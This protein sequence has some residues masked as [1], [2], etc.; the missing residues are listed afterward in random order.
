MPTTR[1][2]FVP[3]FVFF[4][5]W[6]SHRPPAEYLTWAVDSF[7]LSTAIARPETSIH[8]HM[9]YCDFGDCMEAIDRLDADVNS[10]E[11]GEAFF[12]A[13]FLFFLLVLLIGPSTDRSDG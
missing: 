8:T 7:L 2:R 11:N 5:L 9:C 13:A 10:I 1:F 3:P 12:A 4:W 6:S